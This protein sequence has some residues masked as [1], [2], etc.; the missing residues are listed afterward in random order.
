MLRL[1]IKI[2]I[3]IL[4]ITT[5]IIINCLYK[6]EKLIERNNKLPKIL[7][8]D[9]HTNMIINETYNKYLFKNCI[10][11]CRFE[12]L[13]NNGSVEKYNAILFTARFLNSIN[14]KTPEKRTEEQFYIFYSVIS[15]FEINFPDIVKK[16][17]FNVTMTYRSDSD[18]HIPYR[19]LH[20]V[21]TNYSYPLKETISSRRGL[22]CWLTTLKALKM[23]K[24]SSKFVRELNKYIKI[25]IFNVDLELKG[26]YSVFEKNFKF[27]LYIEK[28]DC[29]EYITDSLYTLMEYDIIP[30]VYGSSDYRKIL[31]TTSFINAKDFDV[32]NLAQYIRF[33]AENKNI[34]WSYLEWKKYFVFMRSHSA[35]LCDLCS[36]V[37]T[38]SNYQMQV[39]EDIEKWFYGLSCYE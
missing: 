27:F 3:T 39:Y 24:K 30:I 25:K 37:S 34:Y 6:T 10:H 35:V 8:W 29:D 22:I 18:L 1:S 13:M 9:R 21:T 31:P 28:H 33:I 16:K 20:K 23:S 26:N 14:Y 32:A 38:R 5:I 12:T 15:P 17:F 2:I 36:L 19:I 11:K 4:I 7:F